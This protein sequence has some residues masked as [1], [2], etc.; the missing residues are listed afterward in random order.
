MF[1]LATPDAP[2]LR[3]AE[4]PEPARHAARDSITK[5]GFVPHAI[6]E[7]YSFSGQDG[8]VKI[9]ALA[10]A[11][12]IRR[13]PA[14]YAGI[15]VYNAISGARDESLIA[16]LAQTYSLFHLIHRD[17]RFAFWASTVDG[18]RVQAV[19]L[20]ENIAYDRLDQ[21]LRDYASDLAPDRIVGV[22]QGREQFSHH[23]LRNV[24]PLQLTLWAIDITQRVLVD[25]FGQAMIRLRDYA[26]TQQHVLD[27]D[28]TRLAVQMLGATILADT[29]VLGDAIRH[30]EMNLRLDTLLDAASA[31]F[32]NYFQPLLFRNHSEAAEIAYRLLRQVRYAGFV[33]EML[34]ELYTAA[35]DKAQR[36]KL[37]SYD[38]PLYLTRR[39]W[40]TIPVEYL[41]P[42]QRI[43]VDMACG[44]GSFLIAG[45]ERLSQLSD[46]GTRSLRQHLYGNDIEEF[47]AQLA[48]LGLLLSTS[49][50]SWHIDDQNA[51]KWDWLDHNQPGIIVGNPPFSGRR[52]RPETLDELMPEEG[53]TRVEAANAY[54]ERAVQRL[55]PGGFLAMVMPQSFLVSEA[56]PKLRKELLEACNI[57]EIWQLPGQI[58]DEPQ[59]QP[60]A[61]FAQRRPTMDRTFAAARV[62]NVQRNSLRAFEG[63]GIFTAS[64]TTSGHL[65]WNTSETIAGQFADQYIIDIYTILHEAQ[66]RKL[67]LNSVPLSAVATIFPGLTKGK[68]AKRRVRAHTIPSRTVRFLTDA[69]R[70]MPRSWHIDYSMSQSAIYPDDFERH[71]PK[72]QQELGGKK[73]LLAASPNPSWG[74]RAKGAV[75]RRGYYPSFSFYVITPDISAY[76]KGINEEVIAAVVNWHVS[77]AWVAEHRSYPKIEARIVET[78]P[79]PPNLSEADI[80][81]LTDSVRRLEQA[82]A[83]NKVLPMDAQKT[84]DTILRTAYNLDDAM[85]ERLRIIAGWDQ[86]PQVTL[87]YRPDRSTADY[88]ISGVVD[89]VQ[90]D[91]G[92]ITLWMSGFDELQTVPIE[93]LMPG[94]ML[95]PE[96]AFRAKIPY[97]CKRRRS[98]EGVIWGAILPQENTYL[99]EEELV[100]NLER[101]FNRVG[102]SQE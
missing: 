49:Q 83:T 23:R 27:R 6:L 20:A 2:V 63:A 10:F 43:A 92:K 21:V 16:T 67:H 75:E 66:W 90:A 25:H 91:E 31:Q 52:D 50:D 99:L 33:P 8:Y 55:R 96:A 65:R 24:A 32:P 11:D 81:N 53:R 19:S 9:N 13:T 70:V 100:T 85:Y 62:R 73:I 54:L 44:W 30:Q 79:F 88:I 39:I 86:Q 34:R 97:A 84:I 56:G 64:S 95:R 36:K 57:Y 76:Q 80:Y 4:L 1:P 22:K 35:Y 72:N 51:L 40:Q 29:G 94:W 59:V 58:F 45:F 93:P 87:D 46:M 98:L 68:G 89:S 41:P 3:F 74:K 60:M 38:T 102:E 78:I 26:A 12:E 77:N 101:A 82:A 15:T 37:G 42:E 18:G 71:R 47:T 69:R 48:G 17:D 7:D 61:L 28:L 5:R 14:E